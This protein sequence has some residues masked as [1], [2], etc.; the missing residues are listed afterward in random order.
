VAAW[1]ASIGAPREASAQASSWL[2]V[3]GGAGRVE[4][5]ETESL[6]LIHLDTGLGTSSRRPIVV[7]GLFRV[8]GYLGGGADLGVVA[9]LCT[10]GFAQGG[11]GAGLDAGVI[12]RWWG[13]DSTAFVGNLVLGAPWGVTLVGGASLGSGDQ[14]TY[15]ASLGIDLARLTVHRHTGLDWFANPMRSPS[16]ER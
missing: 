8:Q 11:F 6:T 5:D 1:L 12:Q 9:R 4:R 16:E 13:S 14:R 7:G 2:Y 10:S 3:G 15:F